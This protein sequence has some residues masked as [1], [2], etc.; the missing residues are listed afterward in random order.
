[1]KKIFILSIL[2][3]VFCFGAQAQN[4]TTTQLVWTVSQLKDIST[5]QQT[6]YA[7]TF[8]TNGNQSITWSQKNGAYVTTLTVQSMSGTWI[9]VATNGQVVYQVAT[10]GQTGTM[11]FERNAGGLFITIDLSRPDGSRLNHQYSV[12]SVN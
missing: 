8:T 5:S 9:N 11:T 12:A 1:M 2:V 4:I 10:A 3:A 6:T 7:C